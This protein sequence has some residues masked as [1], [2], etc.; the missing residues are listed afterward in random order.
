MGE[1]ESS[2]DPANRTEWP[3]PSEPSP[4]TSPL[5]AK[6]ESG[7]AILRLDQTC[8]SPRRARSFARVSPESREPSTPSRPLNM[9]QIWLEE[10]EQA[11][12]APCTLTCL[13]STLWTRP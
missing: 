4:G 11:R 3:P 1:C 13:F 8:C 6:M 2:A 5:A 9:A 7:A 12:E 10:G